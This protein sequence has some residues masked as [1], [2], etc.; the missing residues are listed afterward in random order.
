MPLETYIAAN[1]SCIGFL[2][3]HFFARP[4]GVVVADRVISGFKPT[5]S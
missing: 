1:K 5:G 2:K 4:M 3:A